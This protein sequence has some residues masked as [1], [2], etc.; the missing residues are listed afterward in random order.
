LKLF[1]K[2]RSGQRLL[3]DHLESGWIVLKNF[4]TYNI[5][6]WWLRESHWSFFL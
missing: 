5:R 3:S 2:N 6:R 4:W 1:F